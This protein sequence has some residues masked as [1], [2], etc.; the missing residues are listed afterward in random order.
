MVNVSAKVDGIS[1]VAKYVNG[2]LTQLLSR[3]D[4]YRGIDF[5]EKRLYVS[6][7][8]A[9]VDAKLAGDELHVRGEIVLPFSAEL[10]PKTTRRSVAA[11]LM[12]AKEWDPSEI[13]QLVFVPYTV[14]GDKFT[15]A[16]QFK[17]LEQ[18]GFEPAWNT[19]LESSDDAVS[20]SEKLVSLA[21]ADYGYECDGLVLV[22]PAAKN[23]VDAYRP[24]G[25]AAFKTNQMEAATRIVDIDWSSVSKDGFVTPVF[26]LEPV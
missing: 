6:K 22:D 25:M 23:E 20:M 21:V 9:A 26:V 24:K 13:K 18:L 8:P 19:E 2:K 12:N 7:L 17:L 14:L 11:G 16:D 4:G 1:S 3:G 15:K 10:S 5:G